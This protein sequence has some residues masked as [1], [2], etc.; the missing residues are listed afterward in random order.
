VLNDLETL[1]MHSGSLC[2]HLD[3]LRCGILVC[4]ARARVHWLNVSAKRLLAGGP[5]RL[6][7]SSLRGDSPANTAKLMNELAQA[8]AAVGNH[9]RHLQLGHGGWALHMAIQV[10]SERSTMML[11]LTSACREIDIPTDALIRL[12][13]LTPAEAHLVAALVAGS[14]LEEHAQQRGVSVGTV[15]VQLK[16]AQAKTGSR[17]QSD[18]V[19]LVLSSA[20]AHLL[21]GHAT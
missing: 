3:R 2:E 10:A 16:H 8:E 7:G 15:R 5:L 1:L 13:G 18:L 11:V 17:R 6:A 21:S 14:T 12:F 20:A 4:D 19:R 9:V